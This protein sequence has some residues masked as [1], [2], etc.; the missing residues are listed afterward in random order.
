MAG[1]K[2]LLEHLVLRKGWAATREDARGMIARGEICVNG[3]PRED[4]SVRTEFDRISR[5]VPENGPRFVGRGGEKLWGALSFFS[6]PVRDACL[7]DLG[8]S[9][10]GFTDCLLQSGAASVLSVDV[11]KGLLDA[12]LRSDSRV[13]LLESVNVRHPGS[14]IPEEGVDGVVADL[15][16]ISL[17]QVLPQIRLLISRGGWMITLVKPQFEASPDEIDKGGIVTL[18]AVRRRI[19]RDMVGWVGSLGGKVQGI[20]PSTLRGRKGN[21]EYFCYARW[22]DGK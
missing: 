21:Q 18:E 8:A 13:R 17:R 3:I 19:L 14:W 6:P 5:R 12:R 16:F 2:E 1:K 11:G 22:K 15:S 10:G 9:T 4:P 20:A 7:A